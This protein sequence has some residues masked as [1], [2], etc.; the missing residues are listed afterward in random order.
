MPLDEMYGRGPGTG[1][2]GP[3]AGLGPAPGPGMGMDAAGPG[4]A[5]AGGPAGRL[6]SLL[7]EAQELAAGMGRPELSRLLSQAQ[8]EAAAGE[9][10]PAGMEGPALAGLE[11]RGPAAELDR[12]TR[13]RGAAPDPIPEGARGTPPVVP[14]SPPREDRRFG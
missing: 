11:G 9:G 5:A 1:R 14:L 12:A 7:D 8:A 13:G 10:P 4:A 6:L 3:A 2:P